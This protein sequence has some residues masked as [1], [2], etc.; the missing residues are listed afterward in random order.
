MT[1]EYG[2]ASADAI[3]TKVAYEEVVEAC[4]IVEPFV[5]RMENLHKVVELQRDLVGIDDLCHPQRVSMY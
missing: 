3:D 5:G 1:N 2:K 4:K